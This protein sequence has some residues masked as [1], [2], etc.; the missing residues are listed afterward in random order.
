MYKKDFARRYCTDSHSDFY[1]KA[2]LKK[3]FGLIDYPSYDSERAS[4]DELRQQNSYFIRDLD[5]IS[6]RDDE[7]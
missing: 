3:K 6:K 1:R 4:L 5:N 7:D 2:S